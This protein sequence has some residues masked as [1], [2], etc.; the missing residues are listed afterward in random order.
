VSTHPR[1]RCQGQTTLP[2]PCRSL[3]RWTGTGQTRTVVP[4]LGSC[5]WSDPARSERDSQV[6][7]ACPTRGPSCRMRH[8]H[9]RCMCPSGTLRIPHGACARR[10]LRARPGSSERRCH[11]FLRPSKHLRSHAQIKSEV[12]VP[13]KNISART[14]QTK[15]KRIKPEAPPAKYTSRSYMSLT[16]G[17]DCPIKKKRIRIPVG[18]GHQLGADVHQHL[19]AD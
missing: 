12:R 1:P 11:V 16:R 13:F 14:N 4:R 18:L 9:R 7:L 3:P 8:A 5:S 10:K 6:S 2:A 15:P 17:Q 19:S